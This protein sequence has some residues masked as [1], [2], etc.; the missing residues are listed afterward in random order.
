MRLEGWFLNRGL[1]AVRNVEELQELNVGFGPAV[2]EE[3]DNL[4]QLLSKFT[5]L[6]KLSI[7]AGGAAYVGDHFFTDYFNSDLPLQSLDLTRGFI[8]NCSDLI[9]AFKTRHTSLKS[10]VLDNMGDLE[11]VDYELVEQFDWDGINDIVSMYEGGGVN[12][13]G[14]AVDY[15]LEELDGDHDDDGEDEDEEED[16]EEEE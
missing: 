11:F 12:V 2:A 6:T 14:S 7:G 5:N 13:S 1:A 15:L 3:A 9:Q 10:I 4:D 16:A 8:L